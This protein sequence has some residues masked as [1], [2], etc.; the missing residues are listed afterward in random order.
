[1]IFMN[2]LLGAVLRGGIYVLMAMGLSLVFGVMKIPNFAHGE[3]Y[4]VGAYLMYFAS[5]TFGLPPVVCIIIAAIGGFLIGAIAEKLTLQ[6][7]RKRSKG[8]WIVNT[9]ML[10][11]GLSIIMQNL[12]QVLLGPNFKG[13]TQLWKGGIGIFGTN[14]TFDQLFGFIIAMGTVGAFWLFLKKTRTGNAILAV[15]EHETGAMLMG[16]ELNKIHTLTFALSSM[17]A[18][19]A[20]AVLL[21]LI[22]AYPFMGLTPLYKSWFVVILVGLGNVEATVVGG[23]M[24]AIIETLAAYYL[25]TGWQDVILLSVIILVLLI[26]PTGLFGKTLKV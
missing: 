23:F 6:P 9:F 14:V 7:L 16:I 2:L 8:D 17:L 13:V 4:M 26:K 11:A 21:S 3:F 1:M 22:P 10:T 18:A 20:G 5:V 24:V 25:G 15:S 19:I 12:A